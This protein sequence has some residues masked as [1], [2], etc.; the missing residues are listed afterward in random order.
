M[1]NEKWYKETFDK[2]HVPEELLGRVMDME[3]QTA[4]KAKRGWRYAMGALAAV[5]GLFVASNG[6]S[7]AATGE[8][9]VSR[10]T[11]CLN[12]EKY[13]RDITWQ[14]CENGKFIG[15]VLVTESVEWYHSAS[16]RLAI[17]TEDGLMIEKDLSYSIDDQVL[18][19]IEGDDVYETG[20]CELSCE[21]KAD[22]EGSIWLRVNEN[23]I[24]IAE[25]DLT[26]DLADGTAEGDV[27]YDECIYHYHVTQQADRKYEVT[28]SVQIAEE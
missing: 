26:A 2:V 22:E 25:V 24:C 9:W 28:L 1:K 6:I 27:A 3:N 8:T 10:M 20:N 21:M 14:E 23:D 19:I 5:F 13:E 16:I 18:T 7:Y 12:G 17:I 11:V 15:M 4:K